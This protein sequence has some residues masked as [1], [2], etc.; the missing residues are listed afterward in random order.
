MET[1]EKIKSH[2]HGYYEAFHLKNWEKFSEYLSDKF[3]YFTDKC[4][5]MDKND[6][7]DFLKR[8]KWQ[9]ISYSV[10]DQNI[11]VSGSND[12]AMAAYS[13]SFTG[14]VEGKEYRVT[15]IETA[16][17]VKEGGKWMILHSHTSNN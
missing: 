2:L 6:F 1:N 5:V 17:F 10:T 15:A 4:T 7:I 3:T 11:L 13:T 9:S 14:T 8:D 12:M 16:I